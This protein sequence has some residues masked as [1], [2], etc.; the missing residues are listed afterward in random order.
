MSPINKQPTS[1]LPEPPSSDRIDQKKASQTL[2]LPP[3]QI[4]EEL[5]IL[6]QE[7]DVLK[8]PSINPEVHLANLRAEL[9]ENGEEM[10]LLSHSFLED[11]VLVV[12]K[13]LGGKLFLILKK[14]GKGYEKLG[15]DL[16]GRIDNEKVTSSF[17]WLRGKKVEDF[18][19]KSLYLQ[20][21]ALNKNGREEVKKV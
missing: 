8:S 7:A 15:G 17:N 21:V 1:E 4:D 16:A 14:K 9:K 10:E 18:V 12:T 13:N 20:Q 3:E 19:N 11:Q 6:D 5:A 2:D